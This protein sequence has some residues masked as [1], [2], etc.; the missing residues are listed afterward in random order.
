MEWMRL[1]VYDEHNLV[2]SRNSRLKKEGSGLIQKKPWVLSVGIL[3]LP[4][5][6]TKPKCTQ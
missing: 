6:L 5:V 2:Q 3:I 1:V 4:F